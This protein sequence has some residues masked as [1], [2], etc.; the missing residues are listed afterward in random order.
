MNVSVANGI[1]PNEARSIFTG[2]NGGGGGVQFQ[3]NSRPSDPADFAK[4]FTN[5]RPLK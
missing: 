2:G 4:W 3:I 1:S 5:G